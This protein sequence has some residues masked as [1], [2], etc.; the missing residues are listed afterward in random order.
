VGHWSK[1]IILTGPGL[2]PYTVGIP[3]TKG[4][5]TIYETCQVLVRK[6]AYQSL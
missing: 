5:T 1:S 2:N 3:P 4:S 6:S